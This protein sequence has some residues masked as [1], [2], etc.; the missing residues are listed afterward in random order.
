MSDHKLP[1]SDKNSTTGTL[2]SANTA[3]DSLTSS[4]PVEKFLHVDQIDGHEQLLV[5]LFA[6][7]EKRLLKYW[8]ELYSAPSNIFDED[9]EFLDLA[10]E[11]PEP[12]FVIPE[13]RRLKSVNLPEYKFTNMIPEK[14]EELVMAFATDLL[15]AAMFQKLSLVPTSNLK[16]RRTP[17]TDCLVNV[18]KEN[19]ERVNG[20]LK[21]G[22][23]IEDVPL[24]QVLRVKHV[25]A[26]K[27]AT[28]I[29]LFVETTG[30]HYYL[31]F[32]D[33]LHLAFAEWLSNF[34]YEEHAEC[35]RCFLNDIIIKNEEV[36]KHALIG[37]SLFSKMQ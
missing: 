23:G 25:D 13:L 9:S 2:S 8:K 3:E 6:D 5:L 32:V 4:L 7:P 37:K 29:R 15:H 31:L 20:I 28:S 33:F 27:K 26:K 36:I 16:N 10:D 11:V 12:T 22:Y 19:R 30:D 18:D 21:A 1:D 14:L 34:D 24:Y 17:T 35:T